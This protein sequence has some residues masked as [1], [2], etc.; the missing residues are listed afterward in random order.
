MQEKSCFKR[1]QSKYELANRSSCPINKQAVLFFSRIDPLLQSLKEKN[2]NEKKQQ[3]PKIMLMGQSAKDL[4]CIL[5]RTPE[6]MKDGLIMYWKKNDFFCLQF[7]P[8]VTASWK[9]LRLF[10]AELLV[11]KVSP[12]VIRGNRIRESGKFSLVEWVDF[13]L[14]NPEYRP[15]N[16]ESKYWK[17]SIRNPESGINGAESRIH[18]WLGFPGGG[19]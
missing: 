17:F 18:Y 8:F 10:V 4:H 19:C 3:F 13:G 7:F 14:W 11:E 1:N 9:T 16:P 2:N 6:S 12:H 15:S 5:M